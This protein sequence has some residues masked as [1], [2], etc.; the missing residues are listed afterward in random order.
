VSLPPFVAR[1]RELAVLDGHL[2]RA[3][4]GQGRVVF[5]AGEAGS[6]KTAL[7]AEFARR[8]MAAQ[9]GLVVA[10]GRCSA[11]TGIGDPYLPFR[12]IMRLLSGIL[13]PGGLPAP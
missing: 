9:P 8:A 10:G 4:T 2:A 7:L 12:E 6:G 13:K 5:V 11:H 1:D 3:L